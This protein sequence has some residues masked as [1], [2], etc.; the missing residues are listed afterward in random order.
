[1]RWE[2]GYSL[3]ES[4]SVI[5]LAKTFGYPIEWFLKDAYG[6]DY[7]ISEPSEELSENSVTT[8]DLVASEQS[9]RQTQSVLKKL[10][11]PLHKLNTGKKTGFPHEGNRSF[12]D[13]RT[14]DKKS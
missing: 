13:Y 3:P 14:L 9:G 1:S 4:E 12:N 2:N 5:F 11:R 7:L 8:A 6:V 10:F